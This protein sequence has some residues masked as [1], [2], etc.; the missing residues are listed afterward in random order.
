MGLLSAAGCSPPEQ[1]EVVPATQL[2]TNAKLH[3]KYVTVTGVLGISGGFMGSTTCKAGRCDLELAPPEPGWKPPKEVR[4]TTTIRVSV[5]SG[6]NEMAELPA[7]YSR[8]DL[9][10]KTMGGKVLS[11]GDRV[12][13][14]GNLDCHGNN[15]EDRLPCHMDVAR[16][17]AP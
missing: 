11:A 2:F 16:I 17:D 9:K 8:A 5:G 13:V 7:K 3:H 14:S 12:K 15:G 6:P 1:G 4:S 10:V